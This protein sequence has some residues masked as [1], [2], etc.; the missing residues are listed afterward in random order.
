QVDAGGP[1]A[2]PP[3]PRPGTPG[4]AV[5]AVG[6][7]HGSPR[8]LVALPRAAVL[9]LWAGAYLRGDVG[10]DDA[11]ELS[12]GVGRSGPAEGADLF[13]WLTGL[14]RLPLAQLRLA[15]PV[16]GRIA[17]LVGPP[18]AV[19]SALENEQAVV[20]T[21]AGLAE[22]TLIPQ[23]ETVSTLEGHRLSV[24]WERFAAPL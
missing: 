17:G 14:R 6:D 10:P 8:D 16:P 4:A 19:S 7:L 1:R 11:A 3:R 23:T 20:V 5:S 13:S 9:M 22:H 2:A 24:S 21:A 18:P 15:L 12:Y